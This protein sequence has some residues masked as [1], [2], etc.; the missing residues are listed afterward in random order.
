MNA[1]WGD[2]GMRYHELAL[3][4]WLNRNFHV[5]AGYPVPVVFTTP[6]DAF[7]HAAHLWSAAENPF[8]YLLKLVDSSGT[9][10]YRPHPDPI[11]YPIISVHRTGWKFRVGQNYSIFKWRRINWPTTISNPTRSQLG[12]VTV[13]EMP[14]A[15]DFGFQLDFFCLRPDTLAG[16]VER[17]MKL[18]RK[19]GATLQTW[20][21]VA[22]PEWGVMKVRVHAPTG[23][24]ENLTPQVPNTDEQVEFRASIQLTMDGWVPDINLQEV[25][26]LWQMVLTGN[27]EVSPGVLE[28]IYS[29][30]IEL[31]GGDTN[32]V[33]AQRDNVPAY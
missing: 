26:A 25:P 4:R 14:A 11:R 6:L 3:Q 22:Y 18:L 28:Q 7:S 9:P 5:A 27:V 2:N 19:G 32:P 33:M 10:L 23:T 12:L 16:F 24:I 20:V 30:T 8:A 17:L 13:A 31:R 29:S 15:W 1:N 21:D